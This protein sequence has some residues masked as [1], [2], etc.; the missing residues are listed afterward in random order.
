M[1]LK[2]TLVICPIT[3]EFKK[4]NLVT[5]VLNT[6]WLVHVHTQKHTQNIVPDIYFREKQIFSHMWIANIEKSTKYIH[7]R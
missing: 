7:S 1:E 3:I 4:F 5:S 6:N 2:P